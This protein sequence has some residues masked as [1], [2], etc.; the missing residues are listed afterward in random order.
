M[1]EINHE[2]SNDRKHYHDPSDGS[3]AFNATKRVSLL[4][5]YIPKKDGESVLNNGPFHCEI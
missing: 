2:S 1:E 3:L 4:E 5:S